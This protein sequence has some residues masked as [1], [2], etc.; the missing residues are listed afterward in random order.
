MGELILGLLE[1][2][3]MIVE[4]VLGI[5]DWRERKAEKLKQ[6]KPHPFDAF[7]KP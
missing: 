3:A 4:P 1:L 2:V 6:M 5:R 7:D